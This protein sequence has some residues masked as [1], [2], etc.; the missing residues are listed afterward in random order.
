MTVGEFQGKQQSNR[1][2]FPAP[3][4]TVSLKY[5]VWNA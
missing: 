5:I 4:P 1:Y 2:I 3:D